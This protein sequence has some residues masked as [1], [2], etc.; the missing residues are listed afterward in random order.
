MS[1]E[2]LV[3][4]VIVVA[5]LVG[6]ISVNVGDINIGNKHKENKPK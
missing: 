2:L 3:F 6:G 1:I 4:G 5:A